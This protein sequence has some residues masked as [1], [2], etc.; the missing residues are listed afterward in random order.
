MFELNN[1]LRILSV[2]LS[3]GFIIASITGFNEISKEFILSNLILSLHSMFMFLCSLYFEF[4][5]RLENNV[6]DDYFVRGVFY[7]YSSILILGVSNVS[8]GIGIYGI[9]IGIINLVTYYI[10][11][12]TIDYTDSSV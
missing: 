10:K 8:L 11:R 1:L 3:I 7:T 2:I 9:I 6:T 4:S 5:E 12:D